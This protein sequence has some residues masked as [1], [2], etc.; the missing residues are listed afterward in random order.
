MGWFKY[1]I[2]LV[3]FRRGFCLHSSLSQVSDRCPECG[4]TR[5]MRDRE[6][7]EVACMECGYVVLTKIMDKGQNGVH[8]TPSKERKEPVLEHQLP[9]RFMIRDFQQ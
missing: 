6:N 7:A 3:I 1:G 2:Q 5:L 8:S 9:T 4:S